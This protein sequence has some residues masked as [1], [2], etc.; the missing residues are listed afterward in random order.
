[1]NCTICTKP[2][3]LVPSA[4][5]R[6]AKFGGKPS[7]YIKL[8]TAH[9]A[10]TVAARNQPTRISCDQC[11]ALMINGIFC[12]ETGCQNSR[13]RYDAADDRW[14]RQRKCFECGFSVDYDDPCCSADQD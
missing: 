9:P 13:S 5:E 2:I 11:A 1:M 10:C 8:F 4:A 12:H 14:V 3:V 7:D 6:A